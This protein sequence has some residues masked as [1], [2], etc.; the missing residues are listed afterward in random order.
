MPQ[1]TPQSKCCEKC[2]GLIVTGP[3]TTGGHFCPCH[4]E[5][6]NEMLVYFTTTNSSP[7]RVKEGVIMPSGDIVVR[8]ADGESLW[9]DKNGKHP[10]SYL[11]PVPK[12]EKNEDWEEELFALSEKYCKHD[13]KK[14]NSCLFYV[15]KPLLQKS[16]N[17]GKQETCMAYDETYWTS[18]IEKNRRE[19]KQEGY[20]ERK[21]KEPEFFIDRIEEFREKA[22]QEERNRIIGLID[23]FNLSDDFVGFSEKKWD[24]IRAGLKMLKDKIKNS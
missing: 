2:I 22:K 14:L 17:Q 1:P 18:V 12:E 20:N 16:Y 9:F 19:A 21:R 10:K 5:E 15:F 4:K 6:N 23:E 3:S 24:K 13:D 8:L 7:E 11:S